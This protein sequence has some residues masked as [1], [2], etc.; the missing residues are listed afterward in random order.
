VNN[1]PISDKSSLPEG[2]LSVPRAAADVWLVPLRA[3]R[4]L[5]DELRRTLSTDEI[6][7]ALRF[8]AED[9]RDLFIVGRGILR[10]ILSRYL[11][12][13]P[14]KLVFRYGSK[15]KPYLRENSDIQ[16]NLGH[17]GG[18]AIYGVSREELGV[19][20]ELVKPSTDWRQISQR[21]FL[22]REVEELNRL[23]RAQ[24][25][26]GFFSCWARKEAYIKAVGE[27]IATLG[28]FYA[29]AQLSPGEGAIDEE[30][31]PREW[32]FKDLNLKDLNV[33]DELAGAIV[34]RFDQCRVRQFFFTCVEEWYSVH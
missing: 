28:K 15:G 22:T 18:F 30:G 33:G 29:G 6:E 20:I 1:P 5:V 4:Q 8:R 11:S 12:E 24:Q 13:P 17:S 23:D 25:L 27:G 9:H 19:D 2:R 7:R 26:R 14:G 21:F 31:K 3:N 16:F 34:T 10:K 32:Y